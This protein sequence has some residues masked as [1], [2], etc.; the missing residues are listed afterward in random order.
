MN[1]LKLMSGV[2]AALCLS[3]GMTAA[4]DSLR[5][6]GGTVQVSPSSFVKNMTLSVTGPNGFHAQEFSKSSAPR[7]SIMQNGQLADGVYSWHMTA[8]TNQA[9]PESVSLLNDG[10][11]DIERPQRYK[12]TSMSGTF[13]ISGGTLVQP[14]ASKEE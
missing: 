7:V 14:D 12:S 13:V 9:L 5:V 10:R 8:S 2:V 6:S 4:A 11:G 3:T 1:K